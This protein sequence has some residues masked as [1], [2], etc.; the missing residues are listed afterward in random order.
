MS[1]EKNLYRACI[2]QTS[3]LRPQRC[4]CYFTSIPLVSKDSDKSWQSA[5][6]LFS[7][8]M[9]KSCN[10]FLNTATCKAHNL[11]IIS[12]LCYRWDIY[13]FSTPFCVK[14]DWFQRT[15]KADSFPLML[16]ELTASIFLCYL[17]CGCNK[18][19][20]ICTAAISTL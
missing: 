13:V 4:Q 1:L 19:N 16:E 6:S 7:N 15:A 10:F 11:Y 17:S 20:G 5:T 18:L 14:S 2:L 8:R 12:N 3:I 9:P